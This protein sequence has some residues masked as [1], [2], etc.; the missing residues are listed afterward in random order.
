MLR[1]AC[2]VSQKFATAKKCHEIARL[3]EAY[4]GD[5]NFYIRSLWTLPGRLDGETL[6][7]LPREYTRLQAFHK[8]QALAIVRSTKR[9]MA[10]PRARSLFIGAVPRC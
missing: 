10:P 2:K 8:D 4:R 7:R 3:L 5:V 9:Q 1:R 6:N